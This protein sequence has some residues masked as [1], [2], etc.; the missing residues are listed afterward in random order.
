M[1][2]NDDWRIRDQETYLRGATLIK[3]HYWNRRPDDDHDHCEFCWA[4]FMVEPYPGATEEILAVGYA[5][6]DRSA[7]EAFPNDYYWV[8]PTCV[9]DFAKRFDWTFIEDP[10]SP[11]RV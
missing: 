1:A 7:D 10:G 4:K 3:K 2:N 6:Q 9:A 11:L 8:C 5:V